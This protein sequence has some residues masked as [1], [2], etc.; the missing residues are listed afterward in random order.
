MCTSE[1]CC[2][3]DGNNLYLRI[4]YFNKLYDYFNQLYPQ[5]NTSGWSTTF[6]S[7]QLAVSAVNRPVAADGLSLAL[8][9]PSLQF[10]PVITNNRP[11]S[12]NILIAPR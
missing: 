8:G 5:V 3:I 11:P 10:N 7:S 12:Q 2:E 6:L 4:V 1:I 9:F